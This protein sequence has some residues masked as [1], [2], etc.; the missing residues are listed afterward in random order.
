M[1]VVSSKKAKELPEPGQEHRRYLLGDKEVHKGLRKVSRQRLRKSSHKR[2][3]S[4]KFKLTEK[5]C[6]YSLLKARFTKGPRHL[7]MA[8]GIY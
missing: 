2:T 4:S 8:V 7:M 6:I 5:I 1:C 3:I